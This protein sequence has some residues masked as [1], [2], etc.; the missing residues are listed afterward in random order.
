MR[1][2]VKSTGEKTVCRRWKRGMSRGRG[3]GE[4]RRVKEQLL[5]G[6]GNIKS[7]IWRE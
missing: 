5:F 7:G 1:I 6:R 4:T 2:A 3:F